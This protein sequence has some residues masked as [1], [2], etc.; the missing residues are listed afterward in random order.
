MNLAKKVS[1]LIGIL[2]IIALFILGLIATKLSSTAL[3]NETETSMLK[4]SKECAN[5]AGIVLSKNL[6]VL[7]AEADKTEVKSM[8]IIIQRTMLSKDVNTLGYLDMAIVTQDGVAHYILNDETAQLGDREYIQEAL[9]GKANISDVIISR[10]TGEPVIMEAVPIK[11]GNQV[12]GVLIGRRDGR[13][14]SQEL[15]IDKEEGYVFVLGS[16]GIVYIHPDK[17]IVKDKRSVFNEIETKGEFKDFGIELKKLGL[18][19]AGI[20]RYSLDG[21]KHI[22]AMAPIPNTNWTLGVGNYESAVLKRAVYLRSLILVI[23][24]VITVI[25][26]TVVAVIGKVMKTAERKINVLNQQLEQKVLQRTTE[27]QEINEALEEKV[28]EGEQ[29]QER[30]QKYQLLAENTNDAIFFTDKEGNIFESNFAAARIYGYSHEEFLLM[31]IS[32][33]RHLDQF[34]Y[35]SGE[36]NCKYINGE[37]FETV[38]YLKNGT[39]IDV[40]V[41]LQ[42]ILLKDKKVFLSIARN[43]TERKRTEEKIL[44]LSYHDQL[45]GIYNRRFYEE[46]LKK[47]DTKQNLPITIAMGD[48]N[49][50]KLINDTFGHSDGDQL[51]KK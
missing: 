2:L 39:A 22:T 46:E 5:R 51:L 34:S 12:I 32:D 19:K 7:Q 29:M 44:Y 35:S 17:Q 13:E 16:D 30:M 18:R 20:L 21:Q 37:I 6:A 8:D 9:N 14:I 43:I 15:S 31:N 33:L 11:N 49:G 26:V 1:L 38:H 48:V 47:I 45:T 36:L 3:L 40:E 27:L 24:L 25:G 42:G 28:S 50:L 41:S 23:A 10:V 4:Y